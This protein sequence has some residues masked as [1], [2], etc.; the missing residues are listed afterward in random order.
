MTLG[1]TSNHTPE[2]LMKQ[3]NCFAWRHEIC[4]PNHF[5]RTTFNNIR[6]PN[7]DATLM[8]MK[9]SILAKG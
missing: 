6:L 5:S 4:L 9:F 8:H 3:I 1:D 2:D 7:F